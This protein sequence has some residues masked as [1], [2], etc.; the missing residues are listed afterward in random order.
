MIYIF[1]V[2]KSVLVWNLSG[3]SYS[4]PWEGFNMSGQGS[5]HYPNPT[6]SPNYNVDRHS[7]QFLYAIAQA[8][9]SSGECLTVS[10]WIFFGTDTQS[11]SMAF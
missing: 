7:L 4:F 10:F 11:L 2:P 3:S 5:I 9:A 6:P 8:I 1:R